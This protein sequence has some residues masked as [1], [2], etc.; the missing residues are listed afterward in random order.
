[1][2]RTSTGELVITGKEFEVSGCVFQIKWPFCGLMASS[3]PVCP[4]GAAAFYWVPIYSTPSAM[5]GAFRDTVPAVK[6]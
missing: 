3:H 5:V 1:M 2:P 6:P 4:V